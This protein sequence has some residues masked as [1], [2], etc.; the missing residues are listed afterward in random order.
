[1]GMDLTYDVAE[2]TVS[3]AFED[4]ERKD[5]PRC[6]AFLEKFKALVPGHSRTWDPDAKTWT[7][8]EAYEDAVVGLMGE[9]GFRLE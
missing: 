2:G 5:W 3:F 1:M 4:D 9:L 8:S 6:E 7:F